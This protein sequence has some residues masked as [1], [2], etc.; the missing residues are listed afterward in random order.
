[1]ISLSPSSR[2]CSLILHERYLYHRGCDYPSQ[3]NHKFTNSLYDLDKEVM[4]G[5][6]IISEEKCLHL[7]PALIFVISNCVIFILRLFLY[8]DNRNTCV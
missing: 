7:S 2:A 5:T 1:M 8:K 4:E 3:K 6:L